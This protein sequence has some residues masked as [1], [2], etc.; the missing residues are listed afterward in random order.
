[1]LH[2][3]AQGKAVQNVSPEAA[4]KMLEG[5]LPSD[6]ESMLHVGA[7]GKSH[8]PFEEASLAKARRYLNEMMFKAWQ[9]LDDKVIACKEFEDKSRGSQEQIKTDIARLGEQ[10]ADLERVKA[11]TIE[12]I[13]IKDGEI[14]DV[15]EQIRK[16][17]AVYMNIYLVNKREM[18]IRRADMAVFQFMMV[19]TK[20]KKAAALAQLDASPASEA[21]ICDTEQGLT[22]DFSDKEAEDK[23]ERMM[24]P[25]ARAAV[26]EVL[27]RMEADRAQEEAALLQ[28]AADG[29]ADGAAFLQ[30]AAGSGGDDDD[31][32]D[33]DGDGDDQ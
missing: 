25:S 5:K 9:E 18:A 33:A 14:T 15:Q 21:N 26:R 22:L 4:A 16:E 7:E 11:M 8:Q 3:G 31:S 27:E 13:N 20:C 2:V 17:T 24:T 12:Y 30:E 32:A 6:V 10:I 29:K 1:M 23:L 28:H 19:L